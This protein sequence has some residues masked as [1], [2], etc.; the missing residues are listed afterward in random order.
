MRL[1]NSTIILLVGI[2]S[3]LVSTLHA[4]P[5]SV[6]RPRLVVGI[7]IDGLQQKHLD[8]LWNYFDPNGFKKILNQGAVCR[9]VAFNIV[10]AGNASDI[11]N[12]MTGTT[13]YY[14]GVVG[15]HYFSRADDEVTSIL[16]DDNQVGIGTRQTLS[17]HHLLASTITDEI[18][19]AHPGKSK[20]YAVAMGP[21]EA[22]MLGGHTARSVAW[23]D[24]V[25]YK[26]ITTGYYTDGLSQWADQM[27]ANGTFQN[28]SNRNWGPLYNISTYL[29][30]PLK[31]DKK[32]GF[33]YD[34]TSKNGKN[35]IFK[36]TPP[37]N[38]LVTELALKI[39]EKEQLGTDI[40]PD[41][42]M[43]QYSVRIPGEKTQAMQ[44]AEKEDIY[45]RL[46]K[47][48]QNLLQ[49]I[50]VTV[51]LDRTLIVVFGN[52]SQIHSP[53]ELGKN[54]IP[55]GYFNADRSLALLSTYLMAIYG[56]EKWITG[57]YGKNIFLNKEKI[58]Q[59]KI[60][61]AEFQK[62]VADFM[63]EFEGIQAAYPTSQLINLAGNNDPEISRLRNSTHKNCMGD[64]VISLLP[65]WME[66]DKNNHPIG[67]SNSIVPYTP[68]YLMGWKIKPQIVY[69]TYSTIDIAPTI[70]RL[71]DIP[72]PNACTGK[73]ISEIS[74]NP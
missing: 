49:R 19:M 12:I 55:A 37:A 21:E 33:Y 73:P 29:N 17:A 22:I 58:S 71:M 14:N 68:V 27:N 2:M 32:W 45:L 1:K 31:E 62:S 40:Y 15:D 56:Q 46:D 6:E 53:A 74:L 26:W 10:S 44:S 36:L 25:N 72:V 54:K 8:I 34:P 51:G 64:V 63:L 61:Y 28:Y 16:Q 30:K 60:N 23:M 9:N 24:D 47:E 59:K 50:D 13:P 69:G 11:A 5:S 41:A 3:F 48:I 18:S 42:L 57:Y 67:E 66:V 65:G 35:S 39:L 20:V 38:G 70:A 4:Q 43:L 52:Q 7:M